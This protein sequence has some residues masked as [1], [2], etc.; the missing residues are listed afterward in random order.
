MNLLLALEVKR[1]G[2]AAGQG[3]SVCV[4]TAVE[5]G[6]FVVVAGWLVVVVEGRA[7]VVCIAVVV[8]V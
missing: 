8:R 1:V 5:L 4:G 6:D 7:E 3:I 2:F